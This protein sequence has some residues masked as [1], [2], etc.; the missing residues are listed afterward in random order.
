MKKRKKTKITCDRD[1][2][3]YGKGR[4]SLKPRID[5]LEYR[6]AQLEQRVKLLEPNED[7]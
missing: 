5:D 1:K 3:L 7:D 4:R 6:L 2:N